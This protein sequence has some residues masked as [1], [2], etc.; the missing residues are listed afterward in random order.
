MLK[1]KALNKILFTTFTL[2]II[3]TIYMIPD[4][5]EVENKLNP[6]I[7]VEYKNSDY[8]NVYLLNEASQLVKVNLLIKNNSK[9]LNEKIKVII[10]SLII[11]N[12][13]L[14][15]QGL[16]AIIPKNSKVLAVNVDENI[17][18]INFSKEI[19]NIEESK[20]L[21]MIES[22]ANSLFELD[23]IN[24]IA[25]YVEETPIRELLSINIPSIIT[26]DFGINK[27]YNINKPDNVS[28]VVIFYVNDIYGKSYYVPVTHYVNDDREK[29]KIIVEELKSYYVYEPNL[30]SYL[31]N[32]AELTNYEIDND[33]MILNFNNSIF[34]KDNKILEEVIYTISYSV[35]ANYDVKEVIFEV[36][37]NE[38]VKKV[39]KNVE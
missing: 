27:K 24:G 11:S 39:T 12:N 21:K 10:E 26:K 20:K 30:I 31:N 3:L 5:D 34:M 33:K 23:N 8:G 25:I 15:P 4:K 38:F 32:S 36:K 1:R 6:L 22:I 35:F 19:L 16:S 2:F 9:D 17:A 28:K 7:T 18:Y 37:E 13:N 14:I 29:I